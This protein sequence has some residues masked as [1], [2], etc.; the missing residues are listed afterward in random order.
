[1]TFSRPLTLTGK[2]VT[3]EPL[4]EKHHDGLCSAVEDGRMWTTWFTRIP[5]PDQMAAEIQKR[6]ELSEQ[7][8]MLPWTIRRNDTGAICGMTTF[9]NIRADHRRLEIGSTWLAKSAQRTPINTEAKL[10]QLTH[11]FEALDCIA[12]EFRT[13]WHNH[14]SRAAV[15]RLGA[16]QDG[17]LRNH[18]PWRDGTMRDLVVFSIIESEWP[19]V[20]LSLREKLT[21]AQTVAST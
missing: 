13:H 21:R 16:K 15:T 9:C 1:M 8:T 5:S 2:H 11:A 3:L 17:V 10:L 19:T 7:G 20:R 18:D 12:V 4:S 6:L 14:V